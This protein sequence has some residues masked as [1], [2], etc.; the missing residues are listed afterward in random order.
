MTYVLDPNYLAITAIVT[1]GYQLAFFIV[2]AAFKFDKV[3]DFAGGTNFV[4][5]AILTA[6]L[7]GTWHAR[8]TVL[9]VFV[10]VWGLRLALFLLMRILQWG[11]DNRFDDKR[12]DLVQF[13]IFWVF[14]AVWCWTVS[15]PVTIVNATSRNPALGAA[16]YVGWAMWAAGLLVEAAADQQKLAF[17][18][19]PE[20]RGRWCDSGVWKWSRHPNYFGE[21]LLWW[22]VFTSSTPV[23]RGGQ[24]AAICGPLFTTAILLFL[25]GI[26]MLERSADGRYGGRADYLEYKAATSPL[27]PVPPA[28]W[29]PLPGALKLLLLELPL[30][31]DASAL[32]KEGEEV[33]SA[34]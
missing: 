17:K 5:I 20:N 28:L 33:L 22:G 30:Y 15:L 2:A 14:Q 27:I 1:V 16:D 31:S 34:A 24:W 29:R 25:S 7:K 19:R 11:K 10:V 13:A 26:P 21:I 8:Q 6:A 32:P 12:D 9:T 23:L 18:N 3:T 4:V